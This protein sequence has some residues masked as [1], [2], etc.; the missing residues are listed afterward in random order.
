MVGGFTMLNALQFYNEELNKVLDPK[1]PAD[2]VAVQRGLLLY[3]QEMV[4]RLMHE[5]ETIEATVQ[6]VIPCSVKLDLTFPVM[7]TCTCNQPHPCRHQLAVFFKAY[8]QHASISDWIH[9]WKNGAS[10]APIK[11]I[12][13]QKAKE[14]LNEKPLA[15]SYDSWKEFTEKTFQTHIAYFLNQPTYTLTMKWDTYLQRLKSKMPMQTEW[16]MLYT[17]ITK[18]LTF[19]LCLKSLEAEETSNSARYFLNKEAEALADELITMLLP[20]TRISRP[21]AFDGFF[22]GIRE[23]AGSLLEYEPLPGHRIDLYRELWTQLLKEKTWRKQEL[24]RLQEMQDSSQS[25]V[26]AAIHLSLLTEQADSIEELLKQL[27]PEQYPAIKYW[28]YKADGPQAEPF[29]QFLLHHIRAYLKCSHN[30]YMKKE[31]IQFISRY[32]QQ[33]CL[34]ADKIELFDQFCETCLPYSFTVYSSHLIETGRHR[35]WVE[36]YLYNGIDPEYISSDEISLINKEDPSLL[37]PLYT[38]LVTDKIGSKNR[39][40]YRAAV[41]YLKKIRT[42]Y[43]K[44]KNLEQWDRYIEKIQSSNKRLRAFQEELKRGK[45]IDAD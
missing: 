5:G 7:S 8:A 22:S 1:A 29:V 11:N 20:L 19:F 24:S 45:L 42:I 28:L 4:Y 31:F 2:V 27:E 35:K 34:K 36:L 43:K 25:L 12:Q 17:F 10:S 37:L 3:R 26:I 9:T 33:F 15:N 41:R 16:K 13:L 23:D 21:F 40:G 18:Y 38:R 32:V 6:D 44:T 30:Y 14:L 39:Q